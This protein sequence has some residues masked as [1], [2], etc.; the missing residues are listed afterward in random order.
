MK[1]DNSEKIEA[2]FAKEHQFKEGLN[3]LRELALK[4]EFQE[5]LKWGAPVY[6]IDN[7]NVL[8]ILSFKN[9]FGVWFFN[10][11]FLSDPKNVLQN[12]Q[13]GKTKAM[14]HWKFQSIKE[15][16][17]KEVL[18]Y[19]KEAI[20]N[21]KKGKVLMPMRKKKE[22]SVISKLLTQALA[23]NLDAKNAFNSLTP[24]K[25]R[26]Y[27]EYIEEAKQEKTK[28]SRLGKIIPMLLEGKGL[29]DKYR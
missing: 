14:R 4:T 28:L 26:E 9:H 11:V 13:D 10:G 20:E 3:I 17:A 25:Q 27:S 12:A 22:A 23:K 7:K 24:Y 1:M 19:F 15:I 18:S 5:T 8:S 21:Q 29:N 6:T 2:F 16:N